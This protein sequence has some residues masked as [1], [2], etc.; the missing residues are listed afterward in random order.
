MPLSK[1]VDNLVG[2]RNSPTVLN[3]VFNFRQ[4]WDGREPNLSHQVSGPLHDPAEMATNWPDVI[5]KLSKNE[6]FSQAFHDISPSGITE[7]NIIKAIVTYEESLITPGAPIDQFLLGDK[8]A[9]TPQQI[10]GYNKFLSFGCATCHQGQNIGGNLFQK[11]GRIASIPEQLALDLG[12]FTSTGEDEDKYVF[13]VPSLRNITQTAPYF[14]NGSIK[15]LEEA[16]VIMA[17]SQ[18]GLT[19]TQEDIAD[20]IALFQAFS[21]PVQVEVKND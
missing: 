12:K 15:T 19:P 20:I 18:L 17:E 6:Y 16:V 4:F 9:L 11:L 7:E 13:K 14:H 5:E 8:N 2:S 1:G 21:A 10:S 3:A